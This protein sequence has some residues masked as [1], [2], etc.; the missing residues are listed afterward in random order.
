MLEG[1]EFLPP[2]LNI[3]N[4]RL[5]DEQLKE[6]YKKRKK[7]MIEKGYKIVKDYN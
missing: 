3:H 6:T 7:K 5:T 2:F 4:I 1:W